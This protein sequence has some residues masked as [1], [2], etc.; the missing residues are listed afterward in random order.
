MTVLGPCSNHVCAL[1]LLL[2]LT[3]EVIFC[4][5]VH[6]HS[7]HRRARAAFQMFGDLR[8]WFRSVCS[9]NDTRQSSE[10]RHQANMVPLT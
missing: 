6:A 8:S 1:C 2:P 4:C 9:W 5:G 7:N 10:V 3:N